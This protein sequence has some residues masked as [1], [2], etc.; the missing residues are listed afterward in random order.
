M[1]GG[2]GT[3]KLIVGFWIEVSELFLGKKRILW[4]QDAFN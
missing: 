3:L 4:L 2:V 1:A